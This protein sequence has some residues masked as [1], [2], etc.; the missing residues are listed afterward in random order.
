MGENPQTLQLERID[1]LNTNA[2]RPKRKRKH[3]ISCYLDDKE[4]IAYRDKRSKTYYSQSEYIRKCI[5]DK[6]ITVIPGI[7]DLIVDLKRIGNNLNQLTHRV[8]SGEVT[9]LGD[10]LKEIKDDLSIAW[11]SLSKVIKKVK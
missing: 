11:G 9:V 3:H 5:L 4:Y 8:N 10:N 7:R 1:I 2:K 6:K